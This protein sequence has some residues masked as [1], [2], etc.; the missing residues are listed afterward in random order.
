MDLLMEYRHLRKTS[1]GLH[2]TRI[3]LPIFMVLL[4]RMINICKDSKGIFAFSIISKN[5]EIT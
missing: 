2:L 4:T 1:N 3:K 5:T